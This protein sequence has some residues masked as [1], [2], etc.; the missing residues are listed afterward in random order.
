MLK[1][2]VFVSGSGSNLQE[3]INKTISNELKIKIK[4]VISD[5]YCYAIQR[6][7]KCAI[8]TITIDR[9]NNNF[10]QKAIKTLA[11]DVDLIVLAGF[12][13]VLSREFCIKWKDKI[14]NIHPSLLPKYGGSGMYGIKVHEAVI[15]NK[16]EY[17]GATV[18]FVN[19]K[20]DDGRI[21]MQRRIKV[22]VNITPDELQKKV[23]YEIE[24]KLIIDAIK[25][26]CR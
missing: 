11:D 17:T 16:E 10:S 23:L 4:Y 7:K 3:I 24:H 25:K 9:K 8:E 2:A 19:E 14:I 20:V 5:R 22:P 21:I 13:S 1:I 26:L 18:H 12:L 6:A 15:S